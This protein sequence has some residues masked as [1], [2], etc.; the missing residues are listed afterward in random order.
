MSINRRLDKEDLLHIYKEILL[1]YKNNEIIPFSATWM[2]LGIIILSEI[3]QR[4]TIS[5]NIIYMWNLIKN[6][7][8]ELLYKIEINSQIFKTNLI[9]TKWETMVG[10][11]DKLGEWD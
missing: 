1:S 6:D 2:D 10:G 4:K 3:S 8:K 9:A 11:R 7:T 5:Y